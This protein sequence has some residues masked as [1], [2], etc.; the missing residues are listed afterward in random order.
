M[1]LARGIRDAVSSVAAVL[2]LIGRTVRGWAVGIAVVIN[3]A[4]DRHR[5]RVADD[6]A[7][8]R[9][10]ATAVSELA[11]TLLPQPTVATAVAI[12]L[13]GILSPDQPQPH[14]ARSAPVYDES[15]YDPY[16]A[17]HRSSPPSGSLWDRLGN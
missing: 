7:Y 5:E 3:R 10:V 11:I 4:A 15:G 1:N 2:R 17:P 6:P 14:R 9:T 8:T 12:L 16:P 13:T